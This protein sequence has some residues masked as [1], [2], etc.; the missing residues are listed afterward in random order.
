LGLYSSLYE[1]DYDETGHEYSLTLKVGEKRVA[2]EK[3]DVY[4]E[5]AEKE[6]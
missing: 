6:T 4:I 1:N 2:Y 3:F 5:L